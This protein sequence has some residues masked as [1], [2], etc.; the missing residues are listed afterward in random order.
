MR[1]SAAISGGQAPALGAEFLLATYMGAGEGSILLE[2]MEVPP[3]VQRLKW[4]DQHVLVLG[5]TL[6]VSLCWPLTPSSWLWKCSEM[7]GHP[8]TICLQV[9]TC[10]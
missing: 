2:Q 3:E 8:L 10:Q 9:E 4:R 7:W 5:V 1:F 6:P